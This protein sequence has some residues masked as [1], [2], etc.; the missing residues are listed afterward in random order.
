MRWSWKSLAVVGALV[1]L[2]LFLASKTTE[3]SNSL[4]GATS[5][6]WTK[7]KPQ[8]VPSTLLASLSSPRLTPPPPP[9]R[10]A[11]RPVPHHHPSR[12]LQPRAH[13][14]KLTPRQKEVILQRYGYRCAKC[15]VKLDRINVDYDHIQPL[16][17]SG[18]P[19]V[20]A[21]RIQSLD[22]YQCLC[23]VCHRAKTIREMRSP[24]YREYLRRKKIQRRWRRQ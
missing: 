2:V 6:W 19:G 8:P 10:P 23:L 21:S 17:L 1:L 9:R 15:Q 20:D 18:F 22:G 11:P 4:K 3:G 7:S 16:W 13:R 24:V 12:L 14:R 5:R